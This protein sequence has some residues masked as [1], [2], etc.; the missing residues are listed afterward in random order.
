MLTSIML[1]VNISK[2]I[3]ENGGWMDKSLE[4]AVRYHY[5]RFPQGISI[6]KR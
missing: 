3:N 6:T 5:D 2:N 4:N 1:G